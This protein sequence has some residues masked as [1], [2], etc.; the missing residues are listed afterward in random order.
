MDNYLTTANVWAIASIIIGLL[1]TVAASL[2]AA[3]AFFPDFTARC[4]KRTDRPVR[5]ILL[6]AG[7]ALIVGVVMKLCGMLGSA[8]QLPM[9][10]SG[11]SALLLGLMGSSG[12]MLRMAR[13]FDDCGTPAEPS[14]PALRRSGTVLALTY[15]LPVV[16]WF[17]VLPLSLL[18]GLGCA[19]ISLRN[20]REVPAI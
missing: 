11:G 20:K 4:E 5:A 15:V 10:L 6:G 7:C 16:G 14:W 17:L 2:I 13:R 1:L 8:G 18:C 19:I 12:Q 9:L 3:H